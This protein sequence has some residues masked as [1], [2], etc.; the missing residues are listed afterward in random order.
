[1]GGGGSEGKEWVGDEHLGE[2]GFAINVYEMCQ[3]LWSFV[4]LEV[5]N[6]GSLLFKWITEL[7]SL[8]PIC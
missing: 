8:F 5:R 4:C 7:C 2:E 1:M 3:N 6:H